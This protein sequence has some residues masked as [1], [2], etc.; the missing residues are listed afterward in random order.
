MGNPEMGS[1]DSPILI[2]A[3]G[4]I[5]LRFTLTIKAIIAFAV[6]V[7]IRLRAKVR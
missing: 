2:E 1:P 3:K 7:V 6:V 5:P 4:V